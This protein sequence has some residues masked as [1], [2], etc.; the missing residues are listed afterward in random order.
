[1]TDLTKNECFD[2]N[3]KPKNTQ[4]KYVEPP[5]ETVKLWDKITTMHFC[6]GI[7]NKNNKIWLVKVTYTLTWYKVD[8]KL[9]NIK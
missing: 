1:M 9:V 7:S 8:I 3:V 5:I 4:I 6:Q 2:D